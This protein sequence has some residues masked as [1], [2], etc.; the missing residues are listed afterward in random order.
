MKF[1][2]YTDLHLAA[3]NPLHRID[4][5]SQTLLEKLR[6]IYETA[7]TENVDA[8]LFMGDFFNSHRIYSYDII[9]QAMDIICL[10]D[11]DTHAI[12][13]QHDL[14]GYNK[15]SYASS[16][17]CFLERHCPR[18]K[19]I[20][21]PLELD[22]TVLY[23]AH[24]FDDLLE[25]MKQTVTKKK[26]SILLAHHLI[27]LN[28]LPYKTFLAKDLVPSKFSAIFFGDYHAG[29]KPTMIEDT[30]FWGSGSLARIAINET[31]REPSFG[32]VTTQTG[33]PVEVEVRKLHCLKPPEE[34]F[35]VS[36][37]EKT[38]EKTEFNPDSF[39]E[40]IREFESQSL[41]IYDLIEKVAKSEG[42]QEKILSYILAKKT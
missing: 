13:G 4:D 7:K 30:L 1:A 32:I 2:V 42:I 8:V 5:Y 31:K 9:N 15:N 37:V 20:W 3:K 24:C 10:A 39:I 27:T 38:K 18:F 11:V 28:E 21:E 23:P 16:A 26:K 25:T 36:L 14:V 33:K 17:V 41:D 22:D 19:T 34:V 12:I 40:R 35:N 6:E 29:M